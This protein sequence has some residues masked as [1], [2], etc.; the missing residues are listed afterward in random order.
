MSGREEVT[1]VAELTVTSPAGTRTVRGFCAAWTLALS[2]PRP[3]RIRLEG[4]VRKD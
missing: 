4:F 2:G 3:A 1:V